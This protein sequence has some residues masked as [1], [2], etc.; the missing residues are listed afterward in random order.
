MPAISVTLLGP[1]NHLDKIVKS[2]VNTPQVEIKWID[3]S[4]IKITHTSTVK[5][6][7]KSDS[8]GFVAN[9]FKRFKAYN[10]RY[11]VPVM[12]ARRI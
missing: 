12:A 2:Y 9:F 8:Q 4:T 3:D 11:P 10:E 6:G 1:G 5:H 7:K